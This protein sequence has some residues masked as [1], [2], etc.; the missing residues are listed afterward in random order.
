MQLSLIN[1]FFLFLILFSIPLSANAV[2]E[3]STEAKQAF[4]YDYET[5]KVLFEKDS[6]VQMVPS[7]MTKLMTLYILFDRLKDGK[8]KLD[9]QFSV[10]ERAWR[11][12]GSKMFVEIGKTIGVEDLIR[13]IVVQSGNDACVVVAEGISGTEEAFAEEMNFYAKKLGL[14]GS[15]FR[16]STGWPDDNHYM[17]AS[18]LGILS[19]KLIRDMGE[20]YHYFS[21][22][23]YV[24]HG[25]TQHNRNTLLG[26]VAGIDGLKTGHTEAG[27]YGIAISGKVGL[28]NNSRRVIVVVNGLNNEK[29]RESEANRLYQ[30]AI[31]EFSNVRFFNEGEKVADIDVWFGK[32]KTVPAVVT[33]D[34]VHTLS[35]YDR[36]KLEVTVEYNSPIAAPIVKGQELGKLYIKK[37]G[38]VD[39]TIAIVAGADAE[40][41]SFIKRIFASF[42]YYFSGE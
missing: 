5:G 33:K 40:K 22:T 16:N 10:S 20:Y 21:E 41:L 17:T 25:I 9:T 1:K 39:E 30:Y 4:I 18:D 15:N 26:K 27:G 36:D 37:P 31:R 12:G 14:T 19:E 24:H 6:K 13:G 11:M 32:E 38:E 23:V 28:D 2:P 3:F 35:H 29:H 34:I 7:S 8:I 42:D